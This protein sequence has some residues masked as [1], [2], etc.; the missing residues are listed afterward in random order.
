MR[1]GASVERCRQLS[2]AKVAPRHL[3]PK[4]NVMGRWI[5][6]A[7]LLLLVAVGI[8]LWQRQQRR[9]QARNDEMQ[10]WATAHGCSYVFEDDSQF[11]GYT[12]YP[13]G[14][15]D[16]QHAH[17]VITGTYGERTIAVYDFYFTADGSNQASDVYYAMIVMDLPHQVPWLEVA[18]RKHLKRHAADNAISTGDQVFDSEYVVFA[19]DQDYAKSAI[20]ASFRSGLPAQS[21]TG[22]QIVNGKMFLWQLRHKHD[23]ALLEGR[24]RFAAT[25]AAELP[26]PL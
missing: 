11:D 6:I 22:M 18:Q 16:R 12:F 13:F 3:L 10:S 26:V 20:S 5:A 4:G 23:V 15:A 19:K 14:Q 7:V 9:L 24:L 25:T 2:I 1:R 17:R 8:P 21:L